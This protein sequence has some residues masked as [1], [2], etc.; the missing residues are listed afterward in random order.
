M[1]NTGRVRKPLAAAVR[2]IVFERNLGQQFQSELPFICKIDQA[3]VVMLAEQNFIGWSSADHAARLL[4]AIEALVKAE[5]AP[6][7][8][9]VPSRGL[10]LLYEDYLIE[11]AGV[12]AGGILQTAR[13]RNDL[14]ATVLKLRIRHPYLGVLQEALRLQAVLM[15]QALR[16]SSVVMPLYTNGQPAVPGSYGHYL[17]AV[18]EAVSRD[19]EG[20]VAAVADLDTSPLGA[21]AIAGSALPI[22]CGAHRRLCWDLCVL[23]RTSLDAVAESGYCCPTPGSSEHLCNNPGKARERSF[24][25]FF[26]RP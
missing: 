23:T 1:L 13:S 15:R 14:G 19:I 25:A 24:A 5:F 4:R 17:A 12:E 7:L 2:R 21:G 22:D 16:Y 11:S 10:Y 18:A 26:E 6:L 20:L 9:R 8:G 3:H